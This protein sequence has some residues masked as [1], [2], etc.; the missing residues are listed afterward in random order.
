ME[1][2][3]TIL[4]EAI[5]SRHHLHQHPEVSGKEDSTAEYIAK[6]LKPLNPDK[7]VQGIGG[8]GIVAVFNEKRPGP[9]VMIRAELDAL[10]IHEENEIEYQSEKQGVSHKCGHD[11]HMS[12]LLGLGAWIKKNAP[13]WGPVGLLFQPAEEIGAGATMM[14]EDSKMTEFKPDYILALHN[15]P[16]AAMHTILVRDKSFAYSSEGLI[17]K[18]K[19]RTAHAGYPEKGMPASGAIAEIIQELERLSRSHHPKGILTVI[20]ARLGQRDFGITPGEGVVMATIRGETDQVFEQIK[21]AAIEKAFSIANAHQ[22][23]CNL[24]TTEFFPYTHNFEGWS[25]IAVSAGKHAGL[26]VE[27]MNTPFRWSED[28]GHFT[29]FTKGG[30]VGL[31]SGADTPDLHSPDYDFP[32]E[33]LPTGM[34]FF[35]SAIKELNTK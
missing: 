34:Q 6:M 8:N 5:T 28:F 15:I 22:L 11:G 7:L 23:Q 25:D 2:D 12:I 17:F 35:L 14:L 16:G 21:N 29:Q 26:K 13:E 31:G 1:I 10:P 24:E 3:E 20:H 19:G 27:K 30:M 18:L 9:F 32:D 33:I 4:N